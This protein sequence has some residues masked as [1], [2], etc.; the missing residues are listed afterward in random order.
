MWN[1]YQSYCVW[2]FFHWFRLVKA[3]NYWV[4][5]RSRKEQFRFQEK[6]FECGFIVTNK[7]HFSWMYS[8]IRFVLSS[9]TTYKQRPHTGWFENLRH[10]IHSFNDTLHTTDKSV[11][12]RSSFQDNTAIYQ[13]SLSQY[14]QSHSF[15]S[16]STISRANLYTLS[17]DV[18]KKV[19][20]VS[21]EIFL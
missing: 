1:P 17:P 19:K 18:D 8:A 21:N 14:V 3:L 13:L 6:V 12:I 9:F 4:G 11:R 15:W 5:L 7:Y 20:S 16:N 2:T 10:E